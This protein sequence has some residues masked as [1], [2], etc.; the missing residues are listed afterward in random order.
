MACEP[1]PQPAP[2]ALR[3]EQWLASQ[4]GLQLEVANPNQ[5]EVAVPAIAAAPEAEPTIAAAPESSLATVPPL[6]DHHLAEPGNHSADADANAAA[7]IAAAIDPFLVTRGMS[8][9]FH[10]SA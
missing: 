5:L 4:H 7:A 6:T 8:G 1:A 9:P 3:Q 10:A 2:L